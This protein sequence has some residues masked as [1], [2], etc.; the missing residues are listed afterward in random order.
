MIA[1]IPENGKE[2]AAKLLLML[3]NALSRVKLIQLIPLFIDKIDID[4]Q[5][6][7]DVPVTELQALVK[8]T[9]TRINA[10]CK[11]L[12]DIHQLEDVGDICEC[13]ML[14]SEG[15]DFLHRTVIDFLDEPSIRTTLNEQAGKH[16]DPHL[17]FGI[18]A[19]FDLQSLPWN[20][21]HRQRLSD[22]EAHGAMDFPGAGWILSHLVGE[23]F[24]SLLLHAHLADD[25]SR[26]NFIS[27]FDR[28]DQRMAEVY[29]R[30]AL[31][32]ATE[33]QADTLLSSTMMNM[34]DYQ[35]TF[36]GMIESQ[37]AKDLAACVIGGAYGLARCVQFG[38]TWF[39]LDKLS[40]KQNDTT[41]GEVPAIVL[42][43]LLY[44]ACCKGEYHLI[45]TRRVQMC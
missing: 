26:R 41:N 36:S 21:P 4:T 22:D 24:E 19:L 34:F 23:L 31:F 5:R 12:V 9:R 13:N 15:V 18:C 42:K 27:L 39:V 17:A 10:H 37:D 28:V 38:M 30:K 8:V 11:D 3:L 20:C 14:H 29:T 7:N 25:S 43:H 44:T 33:F 1:S 45:P 32:E 6:I 16:F 40:R 35:M 2:K